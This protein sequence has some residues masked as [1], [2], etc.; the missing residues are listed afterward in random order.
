[1]TRRKR[2]FAASVP[3]ILRVSAERQLR[4]KDLNGPETVHNR[5]DGESL[6]TVRDEFFFFISLVNLIVLSLKIG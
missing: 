1:M 2:V 4:A 6:H 3:S 5:Q